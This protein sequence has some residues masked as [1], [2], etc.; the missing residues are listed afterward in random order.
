MGSTEPL[1]NRLMSA[2]NVTMDVLSLTSE[3]RDFSLLPTDLNSTNQ[4]LAGVIGLLEESL[5]ST[6]NTT[7]LSNTVSADS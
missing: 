6:E 2:S 4:V 5:E 7:D 3:A 1:R